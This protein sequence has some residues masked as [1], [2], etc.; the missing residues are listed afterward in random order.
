MVSDKSG[1]TLK[2]ANCSTLVETSIFAGIVRPTQSKTML[3]LL[4]Y[5]FICVFSS[6]AEI[7]SVVPS[8]DGHTS[9]SLR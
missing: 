3:L 9:K 7:F 5:L 6:V 1:H 2:Q 8:C 4:C